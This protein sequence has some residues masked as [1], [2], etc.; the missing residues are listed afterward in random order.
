MDVMNPFLDSIVPIKQPGDK[1]DV[2][3]IVIEANE[4]VDRPKHHILDPF[5][6][7]TEGFLHAMYSSVVFNWLEL[8]LDLDSPS[9]YKHSVDL[10][11]SNSLQ[12]VYS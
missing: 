4:L 6:E 10:V 9:V 1:K 12:Y 3:E 8:G 7:G 11:A 5:E 2:P